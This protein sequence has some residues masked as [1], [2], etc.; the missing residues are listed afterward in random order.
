MN[1]AVTLETSIDHLPKTRSAT[2]QRLKK[3]GITRLI[4]LLTYIPRRYEDRSIHSSIA[5]VQVGEKVTIT[6]TITAFKNQ[7]A[8]SGL[9]IQTAILKDA[10][11]ELELVW[12]NQRYLSRVI[13]QG[14][15]LSVW[16]EVKEYRSRKVLFPH[17]FEQ[18]TS[19]HAT[20]H[21]GKLVPLYAETAGLSSK[22]IREKMQVAISAVLTSDP[23]QLEHLPER[24]LQEYDLLT[25]KDALIRVHNPRT[26][27]DIK[28]ARRR[29]AFDELFI[30]QLGSRITRQL[31]SEERVRRPFTIAS[32]VSHI[33]SFIERLPFELTVS[34][35]KAIGEVLGDLELSKP[36]NRFLQGDVG[37]GKTAVAAVAAYATYINDYDTLVMAPTEILAQQHYKTLSEFCATMKIPVQI[38]TGSRKKNDRTISSPGIIVGTHALLHTPFTSDRI[39]LVVIDEQHRFGVK[40]RAELK[41]LGLHPHLLTMTATPI[42]R[43]VALTIFGELDMS[44]LDEMPKNR[45]PIKSWV[46]PSQKRQAA[47][48]WIDDQ[49]TQGAQAYVICP[50]IDESDRE[51]LA[52]TK[53]AQKEYERL[54]KE[55]FPHRRVGL[56]HGKMKSDQKTEVMEQFKQ[57]HIDILVST[58]VVEVGIDVPTATIIIIEG[59]ERFGLAQLHQ[60]RGRVGRGNQQSYCLLFPTD[61]TSSQS[62]RLQFFAGHTKGSDIA[63]YDLLNRGV[64]ELYGTKQHGYTEL[65]VASLS[66]A[67]LIQQTREAVALFSKHYSL[68]DYPKIQRALNDRS[69]SSIAKD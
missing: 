55:L 50:L 13:P 57:Q 59:A 28:A 56:L 44:V 54:S 25:L 3:L 8:R 21:L 49:L 40:Q 37:S 51:S 45:L 34:Q 62:P 6:G 14:Q 65:K 52:T 27:D 29:L 64:G 35:Q 31:W 17:E 16:G 4:D 11:G 48:A 41:N 36:M 7:F 63:E 9:T 15:Q 5:T 33:Q 18:P 26:T 69:V 66:D 1:P 67:T 68:S 24:I 19:T 58:S 43:T 60:L 22:T 23:A 10:T 42:P 2:I 38:I 30:L 20:L 53:A 32:R 12:F 61:L 39:G 47:Y 46:V